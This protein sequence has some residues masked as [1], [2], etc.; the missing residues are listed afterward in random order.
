VLL[1][2]YNVTSPWGLFDVAGG[3]IEWTE[4]VFNGGF[5]PSARWADGTGR[6]EFSGGFPDWIGVRGGG[7][8]PALRNPNQGF[9]VAAIVPSP[10]SAVLLVIGAGLMAGSRRRRS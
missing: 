5:G 10:S 9:R 6:D 8:W 4:E 1:G 2:A 7:Y 3:T